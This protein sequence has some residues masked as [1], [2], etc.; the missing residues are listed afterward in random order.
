MARSR[1][2]I[3]VDAGEVQRELKRLKRARPDAHLSAVIKTVAKDA[4]SRVHKETLSLQTSEDVTSEST[5]NTWEGQV[6]FGGPAPGR[7][8]DPV[9]YARAE[10]NRG[11]THNFFFDST[12]GKNKVSPVVRNA[13]AQAIIDGMM[14]DRT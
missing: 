2:R 8:N 1:T 10:W 3:R 4:H 6:S 7:P 5:R 12:E 11:G 14:K 13:V 9:N